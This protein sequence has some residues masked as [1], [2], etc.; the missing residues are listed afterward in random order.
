[1]FVVTNGKEKIVVEDYEVR[2]EQ[3]MVRD[4]DLRRNRQRNNSKCGV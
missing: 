1:M 3:L 4:H 2:C